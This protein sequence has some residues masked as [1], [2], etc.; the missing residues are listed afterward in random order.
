MGR[1][2][3]ESEAERFRAWLSERGAEVLE[4]TNPFEV[5]RFRAN[6]QTSVIYR[7]KKGHVSSWTGEAREAFKAFR[8]N[9]GWRGNKRTRRR[10]MTPQQRAIR[11]RDGDDCFFCGEFV[12]PDDTSVEHLCSLTHGGPHHVANL[13]LAHPDCN[14]EAGN[15][16]VAE[17]VRLRERMR[18]MHATREH[19]T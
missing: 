19:G 6:G 12:D 5:I 10:Q 4:P 18:G 14:R 7:N 15:L 8:S 11:E 2:L 3:G 9:G 16:S 13:V 17:K 1:L